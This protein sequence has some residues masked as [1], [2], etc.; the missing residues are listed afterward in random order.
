MDARPALTVWA[1]PATLEILRNHIFNWSIWPDFSQIPSPG[2]PF[3]RYRE[4]Q[5][6]DT[7]ELKKRKLTA[8]P[9]NHVVPAVGYHLDSG[10]GSLVFTGDT[11]TN[12]PCGCW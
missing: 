2:A 1:V 4:I 6:G 11:T 8:L 7:V 9:A 10:K 3:L 12:D 5:V